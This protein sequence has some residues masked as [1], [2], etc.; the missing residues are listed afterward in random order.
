MMDKTTAPPSAAA[1]RPYDTKGTYN[2][3]FADLKDLVVV[4]GHATYIGGNA[5]EALV[6]SKWLGLQN[7]TAATLNEHADRGVQIANEMKSSLLVFSGGTL[8]E[9][10]GP[11]PL[12]L[13]LWV[14]ED[15]K[16]WLG[17]NGVRDR[18]V[19]EPTSWDSFQNM[20]FSMA[21][22][23]LCTGKLPDKVV[24]CGFEFKRERLL[25]HAE[26]L[27]I[28]KEKFTY[29]GVND[30]VGSPTDMNTPLGNATVGEAKALQAFREDPRGEKGELLKKKELRNLYRFGN[31]YASVLAELGNQLRKD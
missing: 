4:L 7:C 5:S 29:V 24:A 22:F 12:G 14:L 31:Q 26:T 8:G 9:I 2:K 13:G 20:E 10:T 18:A 16:N 28:R 15:Q 21:Q 6:D 11:R 17:F 27:G 3:R 19:P 25:F 1:E 23:Y 30:P